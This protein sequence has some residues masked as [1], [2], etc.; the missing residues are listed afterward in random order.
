MTAP[1]STNVVISSIPE[2]FLSFGNHISQ[3]QVHDKLSR[4]LLIPVNSL[5][6][7]TKSFNKLHRLFTKGSMVVSSSAS[8]EL[9]LSLANQVLAQGMDLCG[10]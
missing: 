10:R 2:E 4:Y 7:Q 8:V 5:R 9:L 1:A 6:S 3:P